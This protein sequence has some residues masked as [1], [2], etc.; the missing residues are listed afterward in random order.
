MQ[1]DME[2]NGETWHNRGAYS[3]VVPKTIKA[4]E[5]FKDG[6]DIVAWI[7][8]LEIYLKNFDKSEWVE[9]LLS[10]IENK[11]LSRVKNFER[12]FVAENGYKELR[13]ELIK[14]HSDKSKEIMPI[15]LS[16][17][18]VCKQLVKESV[19]D[20]G[21]KT[22]EG[23]KNLFPSV[24]NSIDIDRVMQ[25]RFV[26]GL[27]NQR[28]REQTRSKMLKMKNIKKDENF[29]INDLIKYAEYKMASYD[30]D[31]VKTSNVS[32]S[33]ESDSQQEKSLIKNN[34]QLEP[35]ISYPPFNKFKSRHYNQNN[36]N[37]N[38]QNAR[39]QFKQNNQQINSESNDLNKILVLG[40][41][42]NKKNY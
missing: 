22:I 32:N 18:S 12:F 39:Y 9:I 41:S 27:L 36:W 21:N 6:M 14:L 33:S 35:N 3:N 26:E 30:S 10:N 7:T 17:L 24:H 15:N 34:Q 40:Q 37:N 19:Q 38:I 11:V 5:E 2:R 4:V 42:E 8:V 28:L 23:V 13:N 16:E 1:F 25:E 20:F 29:K 31:T